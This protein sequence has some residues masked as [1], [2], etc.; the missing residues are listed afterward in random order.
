MSIHHRSTC[1]LFLLTAVTLATAVLICVA[2][3][4]D[5]PVRVKARTEG[6][7]LVSRLPVAFVPNL[8]QWEHA[9]HYVA[10]VGAMTVFLEEKR[11]TF[12]LMERT[13]PKG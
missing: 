5:A 7:E 12:T 3:P 11:W 8:G 9:A 13:A 6:T 10:R 1:A 2:R 4:A